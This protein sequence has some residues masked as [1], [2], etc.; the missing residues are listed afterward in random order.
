MVE[1]IKVAKVLEVA[2][3]AKALEMVEVVKALEVVEVLKAAGTKWN[4]LPFRP[5]LVGGHCIGV[6]PYYLTHKATQ[7]GYH[8]EVILSGRSV[9]DRIAPFIASKT[10][11]LM[12]EKN[13]HI[14]N[15]AVLIMGFTFKENC[16]DIRNTKVAVI[17]NELI[18]F[19]LK[20][21]VYDPWVDEREALHE[22]GIELVAAPKTA[23]TRRR[24]G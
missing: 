6:D 9:N 19:G 3:V 22:Y 15:A 16:P 23:C 20:V 7:L 8:P 21:D 18:Q 11:K 17:Y 2:E 5:G 14:K 10:V 24:R 12:I 1:T 4:F 13:L